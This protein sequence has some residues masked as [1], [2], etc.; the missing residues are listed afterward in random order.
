M[1][2][3]GTSEAPVERGKPGALE[4][5]VGGEGIRRSGR[6]RWREDLTTLP[7]DATATE[8]FDHALESNSLAQ[9]VLQACGSHFGVCDLQH[10]TDL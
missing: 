9:E 2:V 1:L 8:I 4:A 6:S 7:K 5:I 10:I 3:P